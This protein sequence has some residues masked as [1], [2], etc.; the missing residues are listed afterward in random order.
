MRG[1]KSPRYA[2]GSNTAVKIK[3]STI[4]ERR[5]NPIRELRNEIL[6]FEFQMNIMILYFIS[7]LNDPRC[8]VAYYILL[9][10]PSNLSVQGAG[11]GGQNGAQSKSSFYQ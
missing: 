4:L 8:A 7:F 11:Q 1:E 3:P 9:K 10:L 6:K 2:L 5:D